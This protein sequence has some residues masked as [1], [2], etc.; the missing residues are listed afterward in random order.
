MES[1]KNQHQKW[2]QLLILKKEEEKNPLNATLHLLYY[3]K[4]GCD[5]LQNSNQI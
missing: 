1:D 4:T 3:I 5:T 2:H